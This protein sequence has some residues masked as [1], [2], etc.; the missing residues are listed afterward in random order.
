MAK[1]KVTAAR[2]V[3]RY[4]PD[5]KVT[6][7]QYIVELVCENSQ[8]K[9]GQ[10]LPIYFWKQDKWK[11]MFKFQSF[12][13]NQLLK[14]YHE[15]SILE[16][17]KSKGIYNLYPKWIE[18][19]ISKINDR[20]LYEQQQKNKTQEEID[21]SAKNSKGKKKSIDNIWEKLDG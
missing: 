4:S 5:K 11:E 18:L 1:K 12:R 16:I 6:A 13:V 3:S 2:Y 19:E 15:S 17:V 20:V 7:A 21:R 8:K 9:K 14:K 10:E